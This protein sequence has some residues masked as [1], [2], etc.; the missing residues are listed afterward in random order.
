MR[1]IIV[2][3]II[4]ILIPV[5]V[6][7]FELF[8]INSNWSKKD[9]CLQATYSALHIFDW[10]QTK[11]LVK[12][13]REELNPILGKKPSQ[14]KIDAYMGITLAGHLFISNILPTKWRG[15]NPRRIWQYFSI[16]IESTVV[17]HNYSI[18]VRL[19]F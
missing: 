6:S 8:K 16:G 2:L 11:R 5:K 10:A 14:N 9:I 19:K 12:D 3:L 7:A 17:A 15:I 1:K 4:L 13:G 18:G